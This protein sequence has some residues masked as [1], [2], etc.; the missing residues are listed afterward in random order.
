MSDPILA[1]KDPA[2][3][4]SEALKIYKDTTGKWDELTGVDAQAA[5]M[6]RATMQR[7]T[8]W[9]V[10]NNYHVMFDGEVYDVPTGIKLKQ[11]EATIAKGKRFNALRQQMLAGTGDA[12]TL[13]RELQDLYGR[14]RKNPNAGTKS[15]A[16]KLDDINTQRISEKELNNARRM[17]LRTLESSGYDISHFK[18][19]RKNKKG[20]M[21][22]SL[23]TGN[24]LLRAVDDLL[25][26]WQIPASDSRRDKCVDIL[27]LSC[28]WLS[29]EH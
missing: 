19:A 2:V 26:C 1:E 20:R 18:T 13:L 22:E 9:S 6:Y 27:E 17:T 15:A 28:K 23:K 29:S 16:Q 5:E 11:T 10:A 4:L 24:D 25:Q 14:E 8:E 12:P 21:V 7:A 3:V